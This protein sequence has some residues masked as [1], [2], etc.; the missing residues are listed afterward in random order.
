MKLRL[1]LWP[2][3]VIV[4]LRIFGGLS[5]AETGQVV[6]KSEDAVNALFSRALRDLRQRIIG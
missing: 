2:I 6:G 3:L 4:N 5:A 1:L